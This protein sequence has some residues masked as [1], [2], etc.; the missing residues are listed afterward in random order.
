MSSQTYGCHNRA[1][2]QPKYRAANGEPV[3]HKM[4]TDC[5]YRHTELGKADPK[6]AGCRWREGKAVVS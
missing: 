4:T 3:Q 5:Q 6:C 2:F 1:P